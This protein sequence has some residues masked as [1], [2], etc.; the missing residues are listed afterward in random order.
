MVVV[1]DWPLAVKLVLEAVPAEQEYVIARLMPTSAVEGWQERV[2]LVAPPPPPEHCHFAMQLPEK[3]GCH[4][5]VVQFANGSATVQGF[6]VFFIESCG[7]N[8]AVIGR[9]I[10]TMVPGGQWSPLSGGSD[11]GTAVTRLIQ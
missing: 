6:A 9:F 7:S 11:F 2:A 3:T 10:D 5:P 4:V 1:P 8:C